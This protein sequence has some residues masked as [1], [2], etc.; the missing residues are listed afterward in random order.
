MAHQFSRLM[1]T[2]AVKRLQERSGSL[3]Q[4]VRRAESGPNQDTLGP[5]EIQFIE[6]RDSFYI[7]SAG[8]NGWPYVQHRGGPKGFLKVLDPMT[9]AFADFSGN[10]QYV[11]AGNV[12]HNDRV[13]L[14][15]MDYP[16]QI[17]L[18]ILGHAS[19]AE[20]PT[21]SALAKAVLVDYSAKVERVF[22]IHVVAFDWNCQ[23]HITP[24]YTAQEILELITESGPVS[25]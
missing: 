10:R 1:F 8:E 24:R 3:R 14:F 17:R 23:Q 16:H 9:L 2:E 19:I 7:A 11:T 20:D 18:K 12:S 4:Y 15:L 13:T 5:D 22:K 6:Q 21:D 25:R